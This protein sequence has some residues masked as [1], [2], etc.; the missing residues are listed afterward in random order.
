MERGERSIVV[1]DS[2]GDLI[3]R[4]SQLKQFAPG[5]PLHDRIVLIEPTDVEW[6]VSLNLFDIGLERL[7]QYS[8]LDRERLTNS[9]I[10]LYDFV[11][12]ENLKF[13]H[14]LALQY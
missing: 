14:L 1:I 11:L 8:K 7:N 2:Q 5:E 13:D 3:R 6:P 12:G 10:E 9:I 4:I